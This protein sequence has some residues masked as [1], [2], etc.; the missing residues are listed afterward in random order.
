M[1]TPMKHRLLPLAFSLI[2]LLA[3][4][5]ALAADEEETSQLEA[6]MEGYATGVRLPSSGTALTW[7]AVI[8]LAAMAI[9]ALLKNAKR[10]HLD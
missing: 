3:P 6:R 8:F 9:G 4:V 1:M 7:F 10:T 5:A 2:T